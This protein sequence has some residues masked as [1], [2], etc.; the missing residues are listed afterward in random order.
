LQDRNK[1]VKAHRS[2][3]P[4]QFVLYDD[5]FRDQHQNNIAQ[6]IILARDLLLSLSETEEEEMLL[7]KA[8]QGTRSVLFTVTRDSYE[9]VLRVPGGR[10]HLAGGNLAVEMKPVSTTALEHMMTNYL[11]S[12]TP[13]QIPGRKP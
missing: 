13:I 2:T 10:R 8:T 12:G 5:E 1:A 4:C 9:F 7:A 6:L 11:V 3:D